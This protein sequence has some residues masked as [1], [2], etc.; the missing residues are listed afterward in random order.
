M[1][2]FKFS[3]TSTSALAAHVDTLRAVTYIFRRANL[4]VEYS[5]G[6]NPHMELIFSPPLALGVESL[7]EY[8]CAKM[9][10]EQGLCERLNK[11][12]PN[13]M[14]FLRSF[15]VDVNLAAKINSAAFVVEAKGLGNF[16]AEALSPNFC[17]SYVEKGEVVTKDVSS[18]IFS[19]TRLNENRAEF[20]LAVGNAN[21][22]PDRLVR[23]LQ[24]VHNL[25]GDYKITK[26]ESFVD[27][28]STDEFLAKLAE[29][30][31]IR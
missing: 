12:C 15:D 23:H 30:K 27:K 22:R 16:A 10:F 21:L 6:F 31:N 28:V 9:P 4:P 7:C 25:P 29:E 19:A 11:V 5:H 20:V 1:A 24:N 26:I 3:K 17:I 2:V 14:S 18:R 8:V 13:G